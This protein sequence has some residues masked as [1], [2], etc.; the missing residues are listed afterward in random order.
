M[1]VKTSKNKY[2]YD[3]S[4]TITLIETSKDKTKFI[5][6]IQDE[7]NKEKLVIVNK[8]TNDVKIVKSETGF[9][10]IVFSDDNKKVVF[11]T[12]VIAN[13]EV[14]LSNFLCNKIIRSQEPDYTGYN[15]DNK[16]ALYLNDNEIET[17]PVLDIFKGEE[18]LKI[19][20]NND[21]SKYY[22][23]KTLANHRKILETPWRNIKKMLQKN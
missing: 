2:F 17:L 22:I 6:K 5:I 20:F 10:N 7:D 18:A 21:L 9:N 14:D 3:V 8:T 11:L 12:E 15:N 16:F 13:T 19:I 23:R 4:K 1:L